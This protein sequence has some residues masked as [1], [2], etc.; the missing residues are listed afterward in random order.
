MTL[1]ARW[2][3]E[4]SG[5]GGASLATDELT[6]TD[7]ANKVV[8]PIGSTPTSITDSIAWF[9]GVS[10]RYTRDFTLR[11]VVG[12]SAP[13]WYMA[14]ATDSSAPGGGSFSGGSNPATGLPEAENGDVFQLRYATL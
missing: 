7:T 13:G 11:T 1:D 9:G 14:I 2:G 12:G 3:P 4:A 5:G 6:Y 8:G 10:Q